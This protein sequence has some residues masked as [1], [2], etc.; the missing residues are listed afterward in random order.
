MLK[1]I[2]YFQES[3]AKKLEKTFIKY[4]SDMTKI[5]ELVQGV[6]DCMVEFGLCLLAEELENYDTSVCEKNHLRSDWHVVRK[7]KASVLTS[8]GTLHYHKTWF[9]NKKTRAY[10]C[11]LDQA[12]GLSAHSRMTEDAEARILEEAVQTSYEK[13]GK[14]VSIS[15]IEEVSRETVKNKI[16]ELRFPKKETYPEQKKEVEYL[17]IEADEDHVAL[18]FR[19]KKGDVIEN[20]YHQKNNGAIAKLIYVHEGIEKERENSHRHVLRN[21]YYFC[22]VCE[23]EEN[24]RLW[25]EVYEYIENTYELSKVKKIYLS[26]DGGSWIKSGKKQIAGIT[27]VLDEFHIKKYLRKITRCFG[28]QRKEVEEELITMICKG[29]KKRFAERIE[30][31]KEEL[32]YP[33]GKKGIEEGKNYI[34]KNWTSAKLRL[35]R[36]SGI[37]GSS[38][39]GHVSHILSDRMSSR[40]MGWSKK[41]MAKMAELR[42]YYYNGGDMLELVRYQKEELPKVVGNE[43]IIYSSSQMWRE[44]RKRRTELGQLADMKVYSIPYT[45]IKKI[46][47]FKAQIFGL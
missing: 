39:E 34:L 1:S 15:S 10:Q 45:Q 14:N 22:R 25:D 11:F 8:L 40:P 3:I 29:T 23:G 47:N 4:S 21:P 46:A 16:H 2:T 41:G 35:L 43:D 30:E 12:M 27:Y 9:R 42:A 38:T 18:Q 32:W 19:E 28:K 20:A 44:E 33:R 17:Y 5:A 6:T 24:K 31:I 26:A 37:E 36:E 13:G 7:E